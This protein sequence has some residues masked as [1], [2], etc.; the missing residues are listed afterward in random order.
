MKKTAACLLIAFF[1]TASCLFAQSA[2]LKG[3]VV[4]QKGNGLQGATIVL[5]QLPDSSRASIQTADANGNYGFSKI[6]N[7]TYV[8]KVSMTGFVSHTSEPFTVK[9]DGLI[10]L[11]SLAEEAGVLKDVTVTSL[12]PKLEQKSDRLVVNVEKMNT[13]GDNALDVLRKAP[14]IRLDKDDNILFRNNGGVVVLIDGK[15]SYMSGSELSNYLKN[16]P[17][18]VISKIELI[19]NPPANYDAEGTAG[20]INIRLKRNKL[21]GINGTA[22][23]TASY[24]RYGK[25]SGGLNLNYNTGKISS[26]IRTNA[27][28]SNSYNELKLGRTIGSELYNQ[29]NY[30]HP[31]GSSYSYTAGA[32]Y[33]ASKKH[34]FGFLFRGYNS[35]Q[36]AEVTSNS[37]T[38]NSAGAKVNGADM[39]KPQ[40]T[41]G[42]SY[43]FNLNYAFEIDT[44]GQKLSMDADYINGGNTNTEQFFN[45]YVDAA[46]K[47]IGDT[48]KL[49]NNNPSSYSIRSFKMDYVY[50]FAK[51]WRL[52]TGLKS[53]RV[54]T[55]NDARFDSLKT[56]GWVTD[57]KRSNHF[58]YDEN[59]NAFYLTVDKKIG[60]LFE[61]KAGLR[62]EQTRST[63]NSIGSG[64]PEVKRDYWTLAPS[65]FLTYH[66]GGDNQFNLS[67]SG[68]I[69]RPGYGSLNPF[70]FYSDPYTAIKGNPYLLASFSK[71]FLF[72]Y[73][74]KNFQV[75]SLSYIKVDNTVTNIITQNDATKESIAEYQ[76]MGNTKSFSATS[77]GSFNITT[78]WNMN[79]ELDGAYDI[80]NSKVQSVDYHAERFSWSGNLDQTFILPSNYK[81][82]L[83]AMYY[84]ASVSGL[85]RT[86][87][88]SQVDLGINKTF[89]D[90]KATISFK[91]RDVFFGNRYRSV[92]QYN[93]VNTTWQNEWESRR[94]SLSFTYQFGNMKIK[95]A[96]NRSTGAS[97]EQ[98]RL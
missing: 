73:N 83:T 67:Y 68:R 66:A 32:D 49:R 26:Y 17:G 81:I 79:A 62:A 61:V 31:I 14:G 75:L 16:L 82:Q 13:T 56:A 87:P 15:R 70:T 80:V 54:S 28:Y 59:I 63:A 6:K 46:G 5:V 98:N 22:T 91:V 71:S 40:H 90:K 58:L 34:T 9:G 45:A 36:H 7:G 69:S 77:A 21:Q 19:A 39:F 2:V 92:L 97:S 44:T 55:D 50:P 96:R 93:N 72:S 35:P 51:T 88:G 85:A 27:G 24:G 20:I 65:F 78:W 52:E 8:V 47:L 94:F 29:V 18:N 86:L 41:N 3:K 60:T 33:F 84:S 23:A 11:V 25:A 37:V 38:L 48:I 95:A 64:T 53:S 10:R 4:S 89:L 30:W 1:A 76:N 43:V 57:P 74:F 42:R 12:T